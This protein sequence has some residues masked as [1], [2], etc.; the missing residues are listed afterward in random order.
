PRKADITNDVPKSDDATLWRKRFH[1]S[2]DPGRPANVHV[3]VDGW[4]NQQF[5]LLFPDWLRANPDVRSEYL[6]VKRRA[7]TAADYTEAKE[8]WLMDAY[9]RAWEWATA[10]SWRP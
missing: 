4:P 7:Q 1:A 10:T 9:C 8:P 6:A 5:A 2:A 3:R